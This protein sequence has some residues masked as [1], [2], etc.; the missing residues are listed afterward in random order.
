MSKKQKKTAPKRGSKKPARRTTA[1][2]SKVTA[3][4]ALK[5]AMAAEKR[6]LG[7]EGADPETTAGL[8]VTYMEKIEAMLDECQLGMTHP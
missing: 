6:A 8:I 3:G 2:P 1:P 5:K 7:P 4:R